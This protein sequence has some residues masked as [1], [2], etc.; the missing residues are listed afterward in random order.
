MIMSSV[1]LSALIDNVTAVVIDHA[2]E[3][4]ELDSAIGDAD[5]GINMK[6]G[7]EAVREARDAIS[8]LP[9]G[10]ALKVV[11]TKL[12]MTVG[13]ASGPLYGTLAMSLGKAVEA[14]SFADALESAVAAVAAR[15]KSEPGQKT[16]LDVLYPATAALKN[17]ADLAD[18]PAICDAAA[19]ATI[20]MKATR[21]RASFLGDRSIGHM[22]PGARSTAII[23]RS[24]VTTLE[25]H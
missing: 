13:G 6:R 4:T 18:L 20:P 9:L 25:Q 22:D 7:A 8:A 23:A 1:V 21:G 3:L 24:I 10:E 12:V 15:G 2:A 11:G 16:M 14:A 17:G 19:E 5:H